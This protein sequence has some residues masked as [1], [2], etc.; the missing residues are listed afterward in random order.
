MIRVAP[1]PPPEGFDERCRD[2][3]LA[4]LEAHPSALTEGRPHP[5]WQEFLPQLRRAFGERCGYLGLYIA[6]G[7]V[8]HFRAWKGVD[9]AAL[10]YA[11]D[12]YRYADFT[13]NSAKKPAW[14][15]QLLYPFEVEDDWFEVLLPSCQMRLVEDNIPPALRA[16]ARFTLDKLRLATHEDWVRLRSEWLQLYE[17]GDLSLEGLRRVA[18]QVARAVE[19]REALTR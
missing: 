16:R 19:R 17:A 1:T 6:S 11:W 15:G 10:A 5:Y 4:W 8:D 13:I 12:N 14:D 9:G 3:G 7:T 2:R 18:P